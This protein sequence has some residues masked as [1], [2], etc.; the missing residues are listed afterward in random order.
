MKIRTM[1]AAALAGAALAQAVPALAF[2]VPVNPVTSQRSESVV[3]SCVTVSGKR[4]SVIDNG[5]SVAYSYGREGAAPDLTFSV[6]RASVTR[7]DGSRTDDAGRVFDSYMTLDIQHGPALFSIVANYV[8][9]QAQPIHSYHIRVF[10]NGRQL[11]NTPCV[12]SV[13]DR[14]PNATFQFAN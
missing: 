10:Q 1:F 8:D 11:A 13:V 9:N 7:S 3:F 2:P 14:I 12:G 5:P 6:P 4:L